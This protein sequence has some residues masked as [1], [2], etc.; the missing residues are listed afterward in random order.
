MRTPSYVHRSVAAILAGAAAVATGCGSQAHG[1]QQVSLTVLSPSPLAGVRESL[2]DLVAPIAL[3]PDALIAQILPAST[4]PVEVVQAARWVKS[5]PG[6]E[7][8][9]GQLWDPSVLA[10]ARYPTV[11]AMMDQD[12]DWTVR[13]GQAFAQDP[14]GVM[15]AI[16]KLR[17]Q[18]RSVGSLC[19]TAQQVVVVRDDAICIE[20][21]VADVIYVPVYS[22]SGVYVRPAYEC[23][24][25]S[26]V[27]FSIGFGVG[28]WLDMDCDWRHRRVCVDHE[29]WA[30]HDRGPVWGHDR[31]DDWRHDRDGGGR[32]D[33]DHSRDHLDH[34]PLS[35]GGND[36]GPRGHGE[37]S[38][39]RADQPDGTVWTPRPGIVRSPSRVEPA[40]AGQAPRVPRARVP[41]TE[42]AGGRPQRAPAPPVPEAL[43]QVPAQEDVA[44]EAAPTRP[45]RVRPRLEAAQMP[46]QPARRREEKPLPPP[47][48]DAQVA[49]PRLPAQA[50]LPPQAHSPVQVQPPAEAQPQPRAVPVRPTAPAEK[51]AER[52]RPAEVVRPTRPA[53]ET[54]RAEQPQV[55]QP[56]QAQPRAAQPA[57]R[58]DSEERGVTQSAPNTRRRGR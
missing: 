40:T 43:A 45:Q 34:G 19:D 55:A 18:A 29:R 53:P 35:G 7:G 6:L 37:H 57:P 1:Q 5:N 38:S 28:W 9:D 41:S 27:R 49:T 12:L 46:E 58:R 11:L 25:S 50:Q 33:H 26:F 52:T 2:D 4:C 15:G 47:Q 13:L 30:F 10:I 36:G 56:R 32:G 3:Y 14:D 42:V 51:A 39:P 17:A 48:R 8:L 20:P 24:P 31:G 16:Q 22:P 54:R 44:D 23:V 21:A